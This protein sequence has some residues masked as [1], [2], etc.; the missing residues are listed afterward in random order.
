MGITASKINN[1]RIE[2]VEVGKIA[3]EKKANTS[4]CSNI[5]LSNIS[6]INEEKPLETEDANLSSSSDIHSSTFSIR[7]E[8]EEEEREEIEYANSTTSSESDLTN[9]SVIHEGESLEIKDAT[10]S[11]SSDSDSDMSDISIISKGG[12][13]EIDVK[14]IDRFFKRPNL[15]RKLSTEYSERQLRE[16]EEYLIARPET[17]S[18]C[19]LS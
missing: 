9:D 11:S 3:D 18:H 4:I 8:G 12:M 1:P 13:W 14:E 19:I 15:I 6:S 7:N 17:A 2:S 5:N 10:L 16:I